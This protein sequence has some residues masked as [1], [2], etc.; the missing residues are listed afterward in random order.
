[1]TLVKRK[2]ERP[3][4]AEVAILAFANVAQLD[5]RQREAYLRLA[6]NVL[7]RTPE[8]ADQYRSGVVAKV[9]RLEDI[10]AH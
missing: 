1:M 6:E 10:G 8:L 9:S 4:V 5:S 3:T 2:L 7:L